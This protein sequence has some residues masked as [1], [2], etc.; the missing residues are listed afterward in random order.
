VLL[1]ACGGEPPGEEAADLERLD[2]LGA[3]EEVLHQ[4]E[5]DSEVWDGENGER[6][7]EIILAG[8][9]Q[10]P[11]RHTPAMGQAYVRLLG[12]TLYVT[13]EFSDLRDRYWSS[14]IHFGREGEQGNSLLRLQVEVDEEATGGRFTE[15]NRF[16][17]RENLRDLLS[18]GRLYINVASRRYQGGEIRGQIPPLSE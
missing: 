4:E 9:N 14:H 3:E 17:L 7:V 13:G 6:T 1:Y 5:S 2:S 18:Q 8:F 12:D 10:V 16:Y 15:E 11:I